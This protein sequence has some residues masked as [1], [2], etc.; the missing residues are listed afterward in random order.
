MRRRSL[1]TI[2]YQ[3]VET[4]V[5]ECA[6]CGA[7]IVIEPEGEPRTPCECVAVGWTNFVTLEG[8]LGLSGS[9][10]TK[11]SAYPERLLILAEELATRDDHP[12]L[13]V[14]VG[15]MAC[16]SAVVRLVWR[17]LEAQ[18]RSI[19]EA[20]AADRFEGVAVLYTELSGDAIKQGKLWSD[21]KKTFDL[22]NRMVHTSYIPT[23]AETA[24]SLAA[25]HPFIEHL[26]SKGL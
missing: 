8:T 10:T 7:D 18:G 3:P 25:Y 26:K 17:L 5:T 4:E 14:V 2:A 6:S 9:L 13:A 15:A 16:E 11:F 1:L 21:F 23:P 24:E 22:R 19:A 12:G 20:D